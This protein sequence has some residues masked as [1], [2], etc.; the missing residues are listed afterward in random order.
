MQ[1][2]A[3]HVP[4]SMKQT[5]MYFSRVIHN[6]RKELKDYEI[7]EG[8]VKRGFVPNLFFLMNEYEEKSD[9]IKSFL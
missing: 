4:L 1:D 9:F 8:S 7:L 6:Q 3:T 2:T 5:S